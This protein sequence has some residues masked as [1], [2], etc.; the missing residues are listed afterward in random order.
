MTEAF[1][2]D[3]E[4]MTEQNNLRVRKQNKWWLVPVI[5]AA[6]FITF[7]LVTYFVTPLTMVHPN[8]DREAYERL[9][10]DKT[11]E[12]ITVNNGGVGGAEYIS[13]W[14]LRER[15]GNDKIVIY[16][17]GISDDASKNME[18]FLEK[19][20]SGDDIFP[21][22][23]IACIDWPGYGKNNGFSTE[24]SLKQAAYSTV[25]Y[26]K[27]TAA[28]NQDDDGFEA[29]PDEKPG[30]VQ[31]GEICRYK[32]VIV[33]GY[34]MGTGPAVYASAEA[35]CSGLILIAPYACATDLINNVTD[36]FHGPMELLAPFKMPADEWASQADVSSRQVLIMACEDDSRVPFESSISL[37][38]AFSSEVQFEKLSGISH[39]DM[40]ASQKIAEIIRAYLN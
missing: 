38:E 39:G 29:E 13:G 5:I 10:S 23:D 26:F 31:A 11:A 28:R 17:G 19:R 3:T 12:W 22:Y 20:K 21:G 32:D 36:I 9:K 30:T 25:N 37:A 27:E 16:F 2:P 15:P 7:C 14:L 34:S 4:I 40:P 1:P 6:A 8:F 35:G 24:E 18:L 33:A